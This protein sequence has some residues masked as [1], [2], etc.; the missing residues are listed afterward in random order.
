MWSCCRSLLSC[1]QGR[2]P[3][4]G[5]V[6]PDCVVLPAPTIGKD[7][8]LWSRGEKLGVEEL[9]PEPAIGRLGK[10]FLPR[11]SWLDV[12]RAGRIAGLT[13]S[14]RA[15]AMNSGARCLTG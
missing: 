6:R 2:Q 4:E 7:L 11:R 5:R 9:I 15:C 13:Q 1:L 12:S 10:A 3:L 14:R 8:R